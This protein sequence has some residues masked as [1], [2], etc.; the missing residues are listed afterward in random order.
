MY[1]YLFASIEFNIY[2]YYLVWLYQSGPM[3]HF[4]IYMTSA[5]FRANKTMF[6][7][8]THGIWL[9]LIYMHAYRSNTRVVWNYERRKPNIR[10]WNSRQIASTQNPSPMHKHSGI[11]ACKNPY[12]VWPSFLSCLVYNRQVESSRKLIH[13]NDTSWCD[14]FRDGARCPK[15]LQFQV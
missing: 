14:F 3:R 1:I 4:V 6:Y 10:E 2:M 9:I 15:K 13:R 12:I 11:F 7:S 5:F 8:M